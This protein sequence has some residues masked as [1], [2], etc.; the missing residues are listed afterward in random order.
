MNIAIVTLGMMQLNLGKFYNAQDMGLGKALSSAKNAV[1]VYNFVAKNELNEEKII[2]VQE[3]L[4]L[5]QIP[6]RSMGVHSIYKGD[7]LEKDCDAVI[8]FSDNQINLKNIVAI[9]KKRGIQC[10]PYIGVLGSNNGNKIKSLLMNLI[11]N[12]EK[13][14]KKMDVLA[15]TPMVADELNRRGIKNVTVAPVCLDLGH[16]NKDY[17]NVSK[18]KLKKELEIEGKMLLFVGRLQPEKQPLEMLDIFKGVLAES[19]E[20]RLVLIGKGPL[21]EQVKLKINDLGISDKVTYLKQVEN[22]QMWKYYRA[23]EAVIN[24]NFHE[25][26]GMSILEGMYY[27]TKVIAIHA[28]GPDYIMGNNAKIGVLCDGYDDVKENILRE[29]EGFD[30]GLA[31]NHIVEQFMWDSTA[32]IIL[33]KLNS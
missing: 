24:L 19:P 18:A 27:E 7:F 20:Y 30:G 28:P 17:K 6:S 31:H 4:V 10:L 9:C 1:H 22:S 11:A 23:C 26:F 2:S 16:L 29:N 14:Y 21:E 13:I 5:H 15:K 25:I 33:D 32:K 8:C 3:N 12:N